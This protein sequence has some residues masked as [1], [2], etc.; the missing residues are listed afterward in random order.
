MKTELIL[1]VGGALYIADTIH[2]GKYSSQLTKYKKHFKIATTLFVVFSLYLFLKKNPVESKN[3]MGHLNG[4][5]RYMPID[6][7][8]RDLITPFLT[9]TQEQR[10]MTSG[11]ESTARSVSGTKKKWVA[12]Q[13]A[14]KC[15]DC[16]TQLDAWFEVDHKIRLADGG[17][18]HV[19]NLVAL[20]RNCHGK[21]TT[22]E[23]L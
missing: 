3:M 9:P 11:S 16:S 21:K 8:S 4:M 1:L 19:D 20:C 12:A 6:K 18:N 14:W 17:S 7:Q 10:I 15:K 2:D 23:N 5:I 13:Q 22:L